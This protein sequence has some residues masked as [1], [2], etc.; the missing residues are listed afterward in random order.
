M[1]DWKYIFELSR[2]HYSYSS[3]SAKVAEMTPEDKEWIENE[4]NNCHFNE[5][6]HLC[7]L[8]DKLSFQ[9]K[10]MKNELS[11][12]TVGQGLGNSIV[13]VSEQMKDKEI[14]RLLEKIQELIELSNNN[15]YNLCLMGGMATLLEIIVAYDGDE[16]RR[17]SCRVFN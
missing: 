12:S 9:A 3:L 6:D 13:E 16:V 11:N 4:M 14:L 7:Q 2:K 10:K 8:V 15:S 1:V 17:S 5:N